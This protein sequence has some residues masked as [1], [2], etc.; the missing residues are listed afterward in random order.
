MSAGLRQAVIKRFRKIF[1]K[2]SQGEIT[3][4]LWR[5]QI[6]SHRKSLSITCLTSRAVA[7]VVNVSI[8]MKCAHRCCCDSLN[9]AKGSVS[10]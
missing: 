3:I 2:E 7:A 4:L 6:P 10:G 1:A 8:G 9:C 5:P